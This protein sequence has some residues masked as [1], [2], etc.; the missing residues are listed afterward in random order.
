MTY[1]ELHHQTSDAIQDAL[2]HSDIVPR[3]YEEDLEEVEAALDRAAQ[4]LSVRSQTAIAA[5]ARIRE[6]HL[7]L[8]IVSATCQYSDAPQ[9]PRPA[10]RRALAY[11][12]AQAAVDVVRAPEWATRLGDRALIPRHEDLPEVLERLARFVSHYQRAG[13]LTI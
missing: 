3:C 6:T 8:A 1:I 5:Q 9:P 4:I 12:M 13:E 7:A 2:H 10:I 11:V